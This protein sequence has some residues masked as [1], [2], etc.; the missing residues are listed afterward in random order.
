MGSGILIM[1][2]FV[3]TSCG[4]PSRIL[5]SAPGDSQVLIPRPVQC[6]SVEDCYFQAHEAYREGDAQRI[7][8]LLQGILAEDPGP[9][10]KGR[11][12]LLLARALDSLGDQAAMRYY[13]EALQE[14]PE[15]GDYILFSLSQIYLKQERVLKAAEALEELHRRYPDSPLKSQALYQ[16]A[17]AYGQAGEDAKAIEAFEL[18]LRLYPDHPK[19]ASALYLMGQTYLNRHETARAAELFRRVI[20]QYPQGSVAASAKTELEGLAAKGITIPAFTPG[21]KLQQAKALYRAARYK[22]AVQAFQE[23]LESTP[24]PKVREESHL[25]L[26]ISLV[27]L[28]RWS[29][30]MKVFESLLKNHPAGEVAGEALSWFGRAALRQ[31]DPD[32]LQWVYE[33]LKTDYPGRV[34]RARA[35]WYL[36]SYYESKGE[37]QKAIQ[38]CSELIKVFPQDSQA[39]EAYWRIGW[40]HYKQ[41]RIQEALK[42]FD[43]LLERYANTA[44]RPQVLYWKAKLLERSGSPEG[45]QEVYARLCQEHARTYYCHRTKNHLEGHQIQWRVSSGLPSMAMDQTRFSMG[46]DEQEFLIPPILAN[47]QQYRKAKELALVGFL[48]E[49]SREIGTVAGR[50]PN[51]Q[52]VLL[53]LAGRLYALGAYDQSL[54]IIRLYF[55]E[56]LEKG[57]PS[58]PDQFWNQAYPLGMMD[59]IV[60][61]MGSERLNPYLVASIIREESM[62]DPKAISRAGAVGLMQVMPETGRWV[63][64]QLGLKEFQPDQLFDQDLNIKLGAW[65]LAHLLEQFK[66]NLIFTIAAYNAGPEAVTEWIQ[67]GDFQE[68]DEFIEQIPFSETRLYVKKV[69]RSY[70]EYLFIHA[71]MTSP[72]S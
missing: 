49:A 64:G 4:Y 41:G 17:E 42:V 30:S 5:S 39:Q 24:D 2:L 1:L 8:A 23:S 52:S 48:E 62:Y 67:R 57:L 9:P 32:R 27:Q 43:E 7:V 54:R 36:A 59:R 44:F 11:A 29:E 53:F 35:L 69:L 22:E 68:M 60:R 37:D 31:G 12:R 14:L 18:F 45:A 61:L 46:Q 71:P 72:V 6:G 55:Q 34:E 50:Y 10:W 26:G 70:Y 28:R 15:L 40:I 63:A 3:L 66:G 20:W 58:M 56:T 47:D 25:Y 51:N 65:Y 38:A 13:E 21:E 19:V 16:V 33:T